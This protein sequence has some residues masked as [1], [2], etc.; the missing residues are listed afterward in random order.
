R[1]VRAEGEQEQFALKR[2]KLNGRA[3]QLFDG[4]GRGRLSRRG[5]RRHGTTTARRL[6]AGRRRRRVGARLGGAFARPVPRTVAPA[7][8]T[9]PPRGGGAGPGRG[10]EPVVSASRAPAPGRRSGR[11]AS[12]PA[13][14]ARRPA[15]PPAAFPA[16]PRE[17]AASSLPTR[18]WP[19]RRPVFD[20]SS[21]F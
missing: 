21:S 8:P 17:A 4:Q 9:A 13:A 15:T 10:R 11:A 16:L 6:A 2:R 18:S 5:R 19:T 3:V 14:S 1:A 20:T 7:R 12:C